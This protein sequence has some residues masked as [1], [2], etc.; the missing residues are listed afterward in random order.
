MNL[1]QTIIQIAVLVLSVVL[2]EV[3]HGYAADSLGDRT[4]RYAGRLTL[5]PI[6]HLDPVG[7]VILPFILAVSGAPFLV[8]WAK[9]VPFN[10]HN[11]SKKRW[12]PAL[13]ALAGP[14][15]NLTLALVFAGL[16]QMSGVFGFSAIMLQ[17]F[18]TVVIIN[19]VL[20]VFNLIPVPPL[21]GHHVLFSILSGPRYRNLRNF[22][23]KNQLM[24]VLLALF[25]FWPMMTPLVGRIIEFLI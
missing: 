1:E 15:A 14:A 4:A 16:I 25:I 20:M 3:A 17:F 6:P 11:I 13:I 23:R 10:I 9:P 18:G 21:D 8:G 7:S 19:V 22:L 5:N 2:H 12:G 24:M